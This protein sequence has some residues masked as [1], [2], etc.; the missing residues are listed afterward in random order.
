MTVDGTQIKPILQ[1]GKFGKGI[2]EED[3][4]DDSILKQKLPPLIGS[5]DDSTSDEDD[6]S[7]ISSDGVRIVR[8]GESR[9][10]VDHF[11]SHRW[12]IFD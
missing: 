3:E 10:P 12:A 8:G 2:N 11:I 1:L 9:S 6:D 7:G 5:A 4:G